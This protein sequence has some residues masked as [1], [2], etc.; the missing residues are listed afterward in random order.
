MGAENCGYPNSHGKTLR[1]M[2]VGEIELLESRHAPGLTL[3]WHFHDD[4][5]LT[6]IF[7][8][9]YK[10]T[11][12]GRE[13]ACRS[14]TILVKPR[15]ERHTNH[16]SDQGAQSVVLTLPKGGL[17]GDG[18]INYDGEPLL[19]SHPDIVLLGR[20]LRD[21]LI[22]PDGVSGMIVDGVARQIIGESLRGNKVGDSH[23]Y[24]DWLTRVKEKIHDDFR[25][26]LKLAELAVIAGVHPDHLSRAFKRHVGMLVG[27]YIRSCRLEWTCGRLMGTAEPIADIALAAGFSDQSHFTKHFKRRFANTPARFRR[28]RS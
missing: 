6:Y 19:F 20:R 23:A 1:H 21:E 8:G 5:C 3:D 26:P 28:L 18:S 12:R 4:S 25:E 11:Y 24:P 16:F 27:E 17:G 14:G 22:A 10:E 13:L 2:A 7:D 9:Q 15:G